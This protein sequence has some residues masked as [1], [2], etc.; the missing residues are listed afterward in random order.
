MRK[1]IV[2][3][4]VAL[5][6]S[7][8]AFGAMLVSRSGDST[9]RAPS[10][11]R[12]R[13]EAP[14]KA[15]RVGGAEASAANGGGDPSRSEKPKKSER[16]AKS[17]RRQLDLAQYRRWSEELVQFDDE[18]RRGA[19]IQEIRE[20][21]RSDDANL[22]FTGLI[23]VQAL[24]D[25]RGGW[26][27]LVY[28]VRGYAESDDP[29]LR[30][31]GLRALAALSPGPEDMPVVQSAIGDPNPNVRIASG[32][33]DMAIARRQ[34]D[35]AHSD[36]FQKLLSDDGPEVVQ[37]SIRVLVRAISWDHPLDRRIAELSR[38]ERYAERVIGELLASR[39][40][41]SALAT[42]ALIDALLKP[43]PKL[44]TRILMS[45]RAGA[46]SSRHRAATEAATKT[47]HAVESNQARRECVRL[48]GA[49]GSISD[50]AMVERLADSETEHVAIKKSATEAVDLIRSRAE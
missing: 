21:L 45:L 7:W 8:F 19:A 15:N 4:S 28:E 40:V 44:T 49:Y 26:P 31:A 43:T 30:A 37:S 17:K 2:I 29:H 18:A 9:K 5:V 6:G 3:L 23:S 36:V 25:I 35:G 42:D 13:D 34:L 20:A 39:S 38:D 48:I 12:D 10:R 11:H 50:I 27:E 46:P 16:P 24:G 47:L 1:S 22:A 32:E 14:I 41:K 33:L